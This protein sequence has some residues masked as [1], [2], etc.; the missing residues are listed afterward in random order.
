MSTLR[1]L[2]LALTL[3]CGSALAQSPAAAPP[4]ENPTPPITSPEAAPPEATP[5]ESVP[6]V[7]P[8]VQPR[9]RADVASAPPTSTTPP[10]RASGLIT[11]SPRFD[12]LD[13]NG[14]GE[15]ERDEFAQNMDVASLLL[16]YD[17][18]GNGKLNKTEYGTYLA[19]RQRYARLK[20]TTA[21]ERR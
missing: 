16:R 5:A 19:D 15:L 4:A 1:P 10:G 11:R 13:R 7:A 6:T 14:N 21:P 9:T 2:L 3:G 12:E 17:R 18:T 20:A 8:M